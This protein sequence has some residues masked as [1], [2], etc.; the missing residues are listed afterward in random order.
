MILPQNR[1]N[2]ILKNTEP[3][4][5]DKV[6]QYALRL[7]TGR[8]YSVFGIRQKLEAREVTGQDLDTVILRLQ[9]EGWLD[10]R[11]YAERFAALALSSGRYYGVRL[12]LEM[13]RKGFSPDIVNEVLAPL[14]AES[15]EISEVRSAAERRYPG[16]CYS[17]ATDRDKRRVVGFLQRRGF[18]FSSIM[19]ALRAEE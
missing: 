3:L 10:D 14:L 17:T 8:D 1:K 15:D 5:P 4:P 6:Y 7:L 13:R 11:R 19:Q 18:K 16:F 2:L 12:R 9:R